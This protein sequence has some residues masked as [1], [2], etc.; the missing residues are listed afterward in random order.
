MTSKQHKWHIAVVV[1]GAIAAGVVELLTNSPLAHAAW[2]PTALTAVKYLVTYLATTDGAPPA[3]PPAAL[4]VLA[5]LPALM[6]AT[7]IKPP[8]ITPPADGGTFTDCSDAALH[9]AIQTLIPD[10]ETALASGN[11]D[12]ALAV[13]IS[14]TAGPLA[15]A[16]VT[17]AV[18]YVLAKAEAAAAPPQSDSLNATKAAHAKAWL[19]AK[20]APVT[21][22]WKP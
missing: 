8:P 1:L 7:C 22:A 3:V 18:E 10:V 13:L 15:V 19:A 11:W 14:N 4:L 2:A 9:N 17:C 5:F 12:T 20:G 21:G 16:E 6:G